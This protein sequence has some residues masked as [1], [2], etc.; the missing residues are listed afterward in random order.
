MTIF[1]ALPVIADIVVRPPTPAP[2]AVFPHPVATSPLPFVILAVVAVVILY[3]L[4]ERNAS[5]RR[6]T[7]SA[8]KN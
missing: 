5:S 3:L 6:A 4:R 8:G 2:Q 7:A 1:S